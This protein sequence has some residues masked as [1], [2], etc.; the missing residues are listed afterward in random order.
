MTP[1]AKF[2]WEAADRGEFVGQKCGACGK[3]TFPPRPMCPHC[4]SLVRQVAS[5]SGKGTVLSWTM[6]RHPPAFGFTEP[7]IVAVVELEEGPNFVSNLVRVRLQDVRIGM[8]VEVMFEPTI[9]N[10]QVPVFKPAAQ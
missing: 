10:H 9:G 2:F 6:P 8:A 1:D 4:H 7:P 3:F 5:L